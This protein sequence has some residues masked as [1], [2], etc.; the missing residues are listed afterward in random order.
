MLI[1]DYSWWGS[2]YANTTKSNWEEA[3]ERCTKM[4]AK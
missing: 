4:L 1:Q 3:V 2:Q